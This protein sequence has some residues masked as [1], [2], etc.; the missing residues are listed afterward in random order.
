MAESPSRPTGMMG[1][2]HVALFV[3]DIEACLDFYIKVLG[4]QLEWQPDPD[5][6]YLTSGTD[7]LALHRVSET[8]K[9]TGLQRLDHIGFIIK[10]PQEVDD[11]HAHFVQHGVK[12]L[13][14][15]KTHR[16][17]ARSFYCVDP[18]GTMVQLIYHPPI[19]DKF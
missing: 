11:W 14:A 7:N 18:A 19:A 2:R 17:G 4:M 9:P 16:D 10:S 6:Y 15:P 1:M 8:E 13:Q 5:N 3:Q 12:I